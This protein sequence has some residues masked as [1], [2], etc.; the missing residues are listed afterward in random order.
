[1]EVNNPGTDFLE[2]V[3]RKLPQITL[4]LDSDERI[5]MLNEAGEIAFNVKEDQVLMKRPGG[6]IACINVEFGKE[7]CGFHVNCNKCPGHM[8]FSRALHLNKLT[9]VKGAIPISG[10]NSL[11][12]INVL[13]SASPLNYNTQRFVIV[14]I[15]DISN[16]TEIQGFVPV[17]ANC[18]RLFDK[19]KWKVLE[20]F[21]EDNTEAVTT[22]TICPSCIR[23]LYPKYAEEILIN[24]N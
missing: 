1:M 7:E 18:K 8:A 19:N 21:I 13:I 12:Y 3:F 10:N 15:E 16:V 17:C 4:L 6:I 22:H 24:A 9:R 2:G 20:K 5:R 14:T 23:L 11:E